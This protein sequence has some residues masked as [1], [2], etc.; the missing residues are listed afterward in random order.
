MCSML[1]PTSGTVT[2]RRMRSARTAMTPAQ[3]EQIFEN[4][5]RRVFR[6]ELDGL[7][8]QVEQL[9]LRLDAIAPRTPEPAENGETL[10]EL[11]RRIRMN[12]LDEI[13]G[14]YRGPFSDA[15]AVL[16]IG[17]ALRHAGL[18]VP[19]QRPAYHRDGG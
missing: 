4:V 2:H 18:S 10:G 7:R 1:A 16:R 14:I 17:A 3:I 5:A 11:E 19:E 6:G 9:H 8:A 12:A 13:R 15:E